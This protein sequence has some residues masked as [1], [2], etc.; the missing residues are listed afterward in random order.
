MYI[1]PPH[2][3]SCQRLDDTELRALTD[4]KNFSAVTIKYF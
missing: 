2:G 1:F 4:F 3:L